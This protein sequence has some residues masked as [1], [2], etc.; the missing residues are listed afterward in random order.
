MRI[1][2]VLLAV[3]FAA[4]P[5]AAQYN[6]ASSLPREC[7]RIMKQLTRYDGD[8]QMARDRGNELWE[9]AT[10]AHMGRLETRLYDRCPELEP[11]NQLAKF[12]GKV[13]DVAAVAAW[14]YL[15]YKY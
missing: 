5:A 12:F 1:A 2:A 10:L 3:F 6:Q 14:K 7:K 4:A 9:N 13:I 15:T 8:V 11:E